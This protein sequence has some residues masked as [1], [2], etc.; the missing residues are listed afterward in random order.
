MYDQYASGSTPPYSRSLPFE[1]FAAVM[2]DRLFRIS[3]YR[4]AQAPAHAPA[5]THVF[6]GRRRRRA[7]P[8]PTEEPGRSY[9]SPLIEFAKTG[10]LPT[11][12]PTTP[13]NGSSCPAT[14]PRRPAQHAAVARDVIRTNYLSP[15]RA[16]FQPNPAPGAA[17][18]CR[19][20][21]PERC[22]RLPVARYRAD[23]LAEHLGAGFTS[24][25]TRREHH[26]TP[27]GV[28]QPFTWLLMRRTET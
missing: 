13:R 14:P 27:T 18:P 25:T 17:T 8:G 4:V 23:Q 7:N 6:G 9:A 26:H 1:V 5:S 16:E 22:S 28:D 21:R 3:S 11:G 10:E 12:S 24:V 20:R 19:P 15:A 2:S